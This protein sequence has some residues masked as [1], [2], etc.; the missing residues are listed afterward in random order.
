[1][2]VTVHGNYDGSETH[3]DGTPSE[4]EA[5]L[6][7]AHPWLRSPDP[8]DH[9]DFHAL[10]EHLADGTAYDVEVGEDSSSAVVLVV[11]DSHGRVLFGKRTD[12]GKF[13]LVAGGVNPGEPPP[14]AVR[15]ELKEET[16]LDV[17][18]MTPL[19]VL[20]TGRVVLY[21]YS[22]LATGVLHSRNDPDQEVPTEAW[23]WVD[24]SSG[25]P[26]NVWR[27]LAGP[28]GDDNLV[29]QLF[30][31]K[32]SKTEWHW[33][34][35][36]A[37]LRRAE[38][39]GFPC[40]YDDAEDCPD[41]DC[42]H[43]NP[44][45]AKSEAYSLLAHPDPV[46]RAMALKLDGTTP[47]D[48]ATA[49]LDPDPWV[50]RAAFNH[51]HAGHALDVLA[52]S[53][54][55]AAGVPLY[56]RHDALMADPRCN[57]G[58]L[59]LMHRAA[60]GDAEL[61]IQTQAS[62]VSK[63]L[64]HPMGQHADLGGLET[65]ALQKH[66]AHDLIREASANSPA[67]ASDEDPMPHLGHHVQAWH[68][69][70]AAADPLDAHAGGLYQPG[71]VSPKAVYKI[72]AEGGSG[73]Y[74]V[75]PYAESS[76]SLSG[77]NEATSQHLYHAA[78]I[79]HLHQESFVAPHGVGPTLAP[80]TVIHI[81]DAVPINH[82]P[83]SEV[84]A[85]RPQ[86]ADDVRKIALMDFLTHNND[87]HTG[88][89]MVRANGVPMAIDH[90]G[91]FA[92]RPEHDTGVGVGGWVPT[93]DRFMRGGP[94]VLA[95]SSPSE[96]EPTLE[97][98]K[99]VAPDVKRAFE[100]RMDLIRSPSE[101]ERL[102]DGFAARAARLDRWAAD[103][104]KSWPQ[105]PVNGRPGRQGILPNWHTDRNPGLPAPMAKKLG[106]AEFIGEQHGRLA[107]VDAA[108]HGQ[109]D[110]EAVLAQPRLPHVEP[111][112]QHFETNL[113]G[114]TEH[115]PVMGNIAGNEPK[116]VYAHGDRHYMVKP[117]GGLNGFGGWAE[118]TS[119]QLYD[120]AGIGH[121]HQQSHLTKHGAE[122]TLVIHME[123]EAL[124][125]DQAYAADPDRVAKM[126]TDPQHQESLRRM[127]VMD[128]LT[129]NIDRHAANMMV[130]PDGAPFAIDHGLSF[131][132]H[133]LYGL[134]DL[135]RPD[136]HTQEEGYDRLLNDNE[137][138]RHAS[139]PTQE[140]F[141][142]W[143][144]AK[145]AILARMDQELMHIKDPVVREGTR[146]S[147]IHRANQVGDMLSGNLQ[148]QPPEA[149]VG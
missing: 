24:V 56:D 55:D 124:R 84:I 68:Q 5:S 7:A 73:R 82:H 114:P 106:G 128:F 42:S 16:N 37:D 139:P 39:G 148:Q 18:S 61:P 22:V 6:V 110:H 115:K 93:F 49:V 31:L 78:G 1:M 74:M 36:F 2:R 8:E 53:H 91:A 62:R 117:A 96:Y 118:H 76:Y 26:G 52:A 134:E 130:R 133:Y 20:S 131:Q 67:R 75:K 13:T 113:N 10:L 44:E 50:W 138:L 60:Q 4:I 40:L 81:E 103:P 108:G 142:W 51:P 120:A 59:S 127:G 35:G 79:G 129:D 126:R 46:E 54:R 48:I 45:L 137:A 17:V 101:E 132:D 88:N 21:C 28:P 14:D 145:P 99:Q 146:D 111:G 121:L 147:F 116:A 19:T 144:G 71:T 72:P 29:R 85:K 92:Y 105:P 69:H 123:P 23:K 102:R 149:A 3:H 27:N 107:T 11:T 77:W 95:S 100:E 94:A 86:A 140:T 112:A 57:P 80:A 136:L 63:I 89:L 122:H 30:S 41:I 43:N 32:V 141:R 98:W 70:S 119:Q 97:W 66:W 135:A 87:R 47:S 143:A 125:L 104:K 33:D 34:A 25:V 58:H 9:M 38:S 64:A 15:R 65:G 109:I 12:T 90:S 83:V